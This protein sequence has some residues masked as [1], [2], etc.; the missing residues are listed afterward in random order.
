MSAPARQPLASVVRSVWIDGDPMF[1]AQAA[2]IIAARGLAIAASAHTTDAV[3]AWS[4][5]RALDGATAVELAGL[6]SQAAARGVPAV[7]LAPSATGTGQPAIE[8][9][10]ALAYVRSHAAVVTA[11]P[12]LWLEA[13][14]MLS[15]WPLPRGGSVALIAEPGSWLAA[16]AAALTDD[17]ALP[18]LWS[19]L[20]AQRDTSREDRTDIVLFDAAVDAPA[21]RPV[22]DALWIGV[23]ARAELA[24]D[25]PALLGARTALAAATMVGAAAERIGVGLGPAPV[26]AKQDLEI[27]HER[28]TR[29][30]DRLSESDERLGDHET[31]AMLASY[32]V[33]ITRQAVATTASAALRIAKRA[34]FPVELK[35]WGPEVR[36]ERDGCPVET[37]I[38][39]GADVR[40]AFSAV[41]TANGQSSNEEDGAAVIVRETPPRGRELAASFIKLPAVGWTVVVS[42]TGHAV[43]LAAPAPLR[44]VDALALASQLLA[45][46]ASEAEPDRQGLATLLRRASHLIVDHHTRFVRIE[47]ARIV[48]GARG[49]RTVVVDAYA[50]LEH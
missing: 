20:T 6:C 12:D 11:D 23:V 1:A 22:A 13:I 39:T 50:E 42:G 38:T 30:L 15:R 8:Q 46:R 24:G 7:V 2:R 18:R 25:T 32:G 41:L 36:A 17:A 4:S 19:A 48:V 40:R 9:S 33:A 35:P 34:G 21:V 26:S 31:K 10:A 44:M 3:F 43:P 37:N 45:S 14:V 49:E 16:Q 5:A 29:Q 27:D 47:L 28:M